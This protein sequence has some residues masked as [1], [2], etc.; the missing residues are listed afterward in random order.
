MPNKL[1]RQ[2]LDGLV[3]KELFVLLYL[4][5]L[6]YSCAN[7]L[8]LSDRVSTSITVKLFSS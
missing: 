3:F 1:V 2:D 5:S 8:S 6:S 7:A 4:L